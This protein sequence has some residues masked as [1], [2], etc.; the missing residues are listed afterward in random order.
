MGI[1]GRAP[2][3][4]EVWWR[5][6]ETIVVDAYGC[7]IWQGARFN[8]GYGPYLRLYQ[9]YVGPVPAG[10]DLHHACHNGHGGCVNVGHLN[11]VD[12]IKH[13]TGH[14]RE[15]FAK[16]TLDQAREIRQLMIATDDSAEQIG[17]RFGVHQQQVRQLGKGYI[18]K[19]LGPALTYD[20]VCP[21][22]STS[23]RTGTRTRRFCSK[24]CQV[25]RNNVKRLA[26]LRA[27]N[28]AKREVIAT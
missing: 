1:L 17:A 16:M 11:V 9:R 4:E 18:F 5:T 13:R 28:A 10:Y 15:S 21:N 23:F 8:G 6:R 27:R 22:C 20:R 19:E 24:P 2:E 12:T 3:L 14:A 25:Q 7:W 26:R